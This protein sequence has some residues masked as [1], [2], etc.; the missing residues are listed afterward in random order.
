M[1]LKIRH[2][3]Q[4]GTLKFVKNEPTLFELPQDNPLRR[5]TLDFEIVT[6]TPAATT[7]ATT[8]KNNGILKLIKKMAVIMDEVDNKF[9]IGGFTY[10]HAS[11][12]Q[13]ATAPFLSAKNATSPVAGTS[14]TERYT[15]TIDFAQNKN[16]LNDL[17]GLLNAPA[18][19][20]LDLRIDWGSISDLFVTVE[21]TIIDPSTKCRISVDEI[22]DD[23]VGENQ[24]SKAILQSRDFR[25]TESRFLISSENQSFGT[26]EQEE[27]MLPVPST[28]LEQCIV[29]EAN[30]TDGN[31]S[32][33]DSVVTDIKVQNVRGGQDLIFLDKFDALRRQQK[34]EYALEDSAN[35]EGVVFLNWTELR[36]GGLSNNVVDALKF[37]FLT[38]APTVDK[39]NSILV[40]NKHIVASKPT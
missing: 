35:D 28:V 4:I 6:N 12:F 7:L 1:T 31:P 20:S 36:F 22:Y 5:I 30:I 27:K 39:Q 17:S 14:T 16:N 10:Y 25:E 8:P 23:G 15:V 2:K 13:N 37:K 18:L 34:A 26:A 11:K 9:A 29:A 38:S 21:D 33:S 19:S 3:S 40:Y 32:L 24:L